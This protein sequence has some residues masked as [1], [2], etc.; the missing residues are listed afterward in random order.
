V[1]GG[2]EEALLGLGFGGHGNTSAG[3]VYTGLV[4]G[5]QEF[6]SRN[7]GIALCLLKLL[8]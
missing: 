8:R 1:F 2:L 6:F 5:M 4:T 3:G 7:R